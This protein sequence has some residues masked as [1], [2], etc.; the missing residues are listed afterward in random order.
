MGIRETVGSGKSTAA[1]VQRP[2]QGA[3]G[4][5]MANES[6]ARVRIE[7]TDALPISPDRKVAPRRVRRLLRSR[8]PTR[9]SR[10]TAGL[11]P[12]GACRC[13]RTGSRSARRSPACRQ[14]GRRPAPSPSLRRTRTSRTSR[15]SALR[16]APVSAT[17]PRPRSCPRSERTR[18][19]RGRLAMRSFRARRTVN[20][21]PARSRAAHRHR[22]RPVRT[23]GAR[24]A[25]RSARPGLGGGV[26]HQPAD[27]QCSHGPY[28]RLW[29]HRASAAALSRVDS[30]ADSRGR[31]PGGCHSLCDHLFVFIHVPIRAARVRARL[32]IVTS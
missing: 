29:W 15:S 9:R 14:R 12:A 3:V 20:R 27:R 21:T 5:V 13:V 32:Q 11:R 28:R 23:A 18:S 22:C 19:P 25:H 26:W 10:D 6:V 24:R 31:Q 7:A 4:R 16:P 30:R 17:A 8:P 1:H 2:A